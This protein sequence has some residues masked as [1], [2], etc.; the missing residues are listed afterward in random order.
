[1]TEDEYS[2]IM[3]KRLEEDDFVVN[4]DGR[5]YADYGDDFGN[6]DEED[7]NLSE[8][9]DDTAAGQILSSCTYMLITSDA[10]IGLLSN[11][12]RQTQTWT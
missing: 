4:D 12:D 8:A 10:Y 6:Y 1:V 5:G 11:F 3:R 9:E 7:E 2:M